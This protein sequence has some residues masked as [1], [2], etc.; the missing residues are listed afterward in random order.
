[1]LGRMDRDIVARTVDVRHPSCLTM[2]SPA[3]AHTRQ[4][5]RYAIHGPSWKDVI[6]PEAETPYADF[7]VDEACLAQSVLAALKDGFDVYS[8][9]D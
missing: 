5:T 4:A 1:M 3:L 9:R 2:S 6:S 8:V 7:V